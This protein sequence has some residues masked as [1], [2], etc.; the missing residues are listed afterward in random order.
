MSVSTTTPDSTTAATDGREEAQDGRVDPDVAEALE[1][2]IAELAAVAEDIR[3]LRFLEPPEVTVVTKAEMEA[4]VQDRIDEELTPE[5]VDVETRLLQLLGLLDQG[6]DLK[7]LYQDVL[8]EVVVGQYDGD[9]AELVVASDDAELSPLSKSNVVH[10]LIHALSDQHF[11]HFA[12]WREMLD[13]ERYD[14]AAAYQALLE[15]EATYFQAL[16][17]A[18][19]LSTAE[20]LELALEVNRTDAD[21][22]RASPYFLQ[23]SLMFPYLEGFQFVLRLIESGGVEAV[24]QA[25]EQPPTS[26]EQIIHPAR[27]FDGEGAEP[28]TLAAFEVPGYDL[29]EESVWG[30][31]S[32]RLMFGQVEDPGLAAQVGDGWGGDV[33]RVLFDEDDVLFVLSYRADTDRDAAELAAALEGYT[34]AIGGGEGSEV[35]GLVVFEGEN[36]FAAVDRDGEQVVFVAATDAVEGRRVADVVE[37]P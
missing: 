22:F 36:T 13:A 23:E 18:E 9:T 27:Y 30:E 10:E 35:D 11:D 16:Y 25:Y 29:Y 37:L 26:T 28:V 14:E 7:Q 1:A 34:A 5:D 15:G 24:N 17:A 31:L 20:R 32:L 4:R 33:Y 8:G 3:G 6:V 21:A 19:R 12:I 2:E